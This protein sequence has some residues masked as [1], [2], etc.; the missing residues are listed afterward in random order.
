MAEVKDYLDFEGTSAVVAG[1]KKLVSEGYVAKELKTGSASVYKTLTDN[2]LTDELKA[3][4]ESAGDSSF[5]GNYNDL[6]NIPTIN[7]VSVAGSQ[8]STSLGLA[9][10]QDLTTATTDMATKT[11]VQ[12]LGYATTDSVDSKVNAAK[13]DLQEAITAAATAAVKPKGS[14]AFASLPTPTKTALGD[15]Y[16]ITDDFTTTASFTEGAG[17]EYPAGSNVVCVQS[18]TNYLW[19]VQGGFVDLTPYAKTADF[20]RITES[21]IETLFA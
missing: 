1:V 17:K 4:I 5:T 11:Y 12:G 13:A 19:D 16:N 15:M 9:S 3:K 2:N 20:A 21:Q 6:S 10:S 7:G 14:V 18:G 8:T